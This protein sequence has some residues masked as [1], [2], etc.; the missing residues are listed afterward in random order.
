MALPQKYLKYHVKPTLSGDLQH[1]TRLREGNTI[2]T[3]LYK[4]KEKVYFNIPVLD[5]IIPLSTLDANIKG[6]A[7]PG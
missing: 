1:A 3:Y 6:A 4:E 2:L 7:H 5:I